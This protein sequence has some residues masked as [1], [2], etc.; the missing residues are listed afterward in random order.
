LKS[1]SPRLAPASLLL[2][3][4]I[5]LA[6][7]SWLRKSVQSKFEFS[8]PLLALLATLLTASLIPSSSSHLNVSLLECLSW[9]VQ[10]QLQ[11]DLG[12]EQLQVQAQP[13]LSPACHFTVSLELVEITVVTDSRP[14]EVSP[15]LTIV[16]ALVESVLCTRRSR[17]VSRTLSCSAFANQNWLFVS[18][19]SWSSI[20]VG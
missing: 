18:R 15:S 17:L 8:D 13:L 9:Q 5:L 4:R 20:G 14:L 2:L 10:A 12:C 11:A 6:G 7:L 3:A 19:A 16:L 1:H